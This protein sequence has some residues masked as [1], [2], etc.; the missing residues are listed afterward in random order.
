MNKARSHRISNLS[1]RGLGHL[2]DLMFCQKTLYET[3]CMSRCIV[4]LKL[5]IWVA[6]S[7]S[8]LNYPNSFQRGM[9]KLNTKSDADSLL[10]SISHFECD[11]H[12]VHMLTQWHLLPPLTRTVMSHCSC[13]RIPVHSPWLP[14]CIYVTQTILIIL[15]LPGLFPDWPCVSS[16]FPK[17]MSCFSNH[18]ISYLIVSFPFSSLFFS[19]P[20]FLLVLL[21]FLNDEPIDIYC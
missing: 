17:W 20:F 14:G 7:C 6:H 1:C 2:G 5:S 13:M 11:G 16:Y 19:F 15:T 21:Q 9:F 3:W 18:I 12:T 10:Y 4:V 8:L